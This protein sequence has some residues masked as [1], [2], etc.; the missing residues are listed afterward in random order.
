MFRA[1]RCFSIILNALVYFGRFWFI[2]AC[3]DCFFGGF[4]LLC[5]FCLLLIVLVWFSYL[6]AL[7]LL[8]NLVVF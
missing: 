2:W 8:V 7:R 1:Q 4:D 3:A 6:C 5:G